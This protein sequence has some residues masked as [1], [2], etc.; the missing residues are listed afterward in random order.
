MRMMREA[1]KVAARE[2]EQEGRGGHLPGLDLDM[3]VS[4]ELIDLI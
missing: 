3:T 1:E 2:G 4:F